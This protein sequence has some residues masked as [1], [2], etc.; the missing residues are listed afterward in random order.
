[1]EVHHHPE[2]EKKGFKEY[3]LEGLMIF[4]AVTMGFF[5]ESIR[6][7]IADHSK[8]HEYIIS[9]IQDTRTD[10]TVINTA[11]A[12]NK[13][14]VI[15]LD[16]LSDL[17]F[18]YEQTNGSD[19]VLYRLYRRS[20][21]HPDY[22]DLTERTLSQLKNAGGMRLIRKKAAVDSIILYDDVA[23]KLQNQREYYDHYLNNLVGASELLFNYKYFSFNSYSK[24]KRVSLS[25]AQLI[26]HDKIQLIQLGNDVRLYEGIVAFYITRLEEARQ[27]AVNLSNTLKKE[28]KIEEE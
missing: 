28:Y 18:N 7:K 16:S 27:H 22:A 5:A 24:K 1:M 23:K 4:L 20:I 12:L 14:R 11:I 8:E 6:E 26:S 3:L 25:G 2:V 10:T 17:L 15:K 19:S 9:M 13:T 21:A